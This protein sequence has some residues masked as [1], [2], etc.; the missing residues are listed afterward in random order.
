[1]FQRSVSFS[2]GNLKSVF[3]RTSWDMVFSLSIDLDKNKMFIKK[4]LSI[5]MA[6]MCS[7]QMLVIFHYMQGRQFLNFFLNW[8]MLVV[9]YLMKIMCSLV[10]F[11]KLFMIDS[12]KDDSRF[13]INVFIF[14]MLVHVNL[15]SFTNSV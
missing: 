2:R 14:L 3:K 8:L 15:V 1:M 10:L 5:V 9:R 6:S 13:Y 7:I 11:S 4:E 12:D